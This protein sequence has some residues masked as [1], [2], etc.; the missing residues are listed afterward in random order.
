VI[1]LYE[2]IRP[3]CAPRLLLGAGATPPAQ[4]AGSPSVQEHAYE[5]SGVA[6][7]QA[8]NNPISS[9][10]DEDMRYCRWWFVKLQSAA[11]WSCLVGRRRRLCRV[12]QRHGGCGEVHRLNNCC[13]VFHTWGTW[14]SRLGMAGLL[15]WAWPTQL[16]SDPNKSVRRA[17]WVTIAGMPDASC[18]FY[19]GRRLVQFEHF[20]PPHVT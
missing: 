10:C 3:I 11:S 16:L 17:F 14:T 13:Q 4:T 12:P 20:V 7:Q 8:S 6:Q 18:F 9:P 15:D 5:H 1:V 19:C 2:S